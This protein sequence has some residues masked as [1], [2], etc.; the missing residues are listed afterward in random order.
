MFSTA[1]SSLNA[2]LSSGVSMILTFYLLLLWLRFWVSLAGKKTVLK[3]S[4]VYLFCLQSVYLY[5]LIMAE[6]ATFSLFL[7]CSLCSFWLVFSSWVT[8]LEWHYIWIIDHTLEPTCVF[9]GHFI[10]LLFPFPDVGPVHS[11][12]YSR[13]RPAHEFSGLL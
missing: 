1:G 12:S 7:H 5:G 3:Q 11:Q 8:A 13:P 6:K 4:E 2:L 9:W 10:F